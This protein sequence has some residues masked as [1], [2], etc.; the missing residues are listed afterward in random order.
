MKLVFSPHYRLD[1]GPHV[2]PTVKYER[3]RD[4]I[5]AAGLAAPEDFVEPAP[6]AW[7]DLALVHTSAY[8]ERVRT[9]R[10]SFLEQIRLE[11]PFTPAVVTGFRLMTGGTILAARLALDE[12]VAVHLGGGLHHA[13]ADH[14]EGFCLFNDVA[15]AIRVLQRD[16]LIRRAAV[17]DLDVHQ[18]NG[19]A[20]IFAGDASVFTCSL[21]QQNNYPIEKP[22]SGADIGLRDGASDEEYLAALE[23]VWPRVEAARPDLLCY[24]AGA[25]PFQDDQLGGLALTREGLRRRDRLVLASAVAAQVPVVVLLA[26]GYARRLEDTVAIHVATVEEAVACARTW[27]RADRAHRVTPA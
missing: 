12:G 26:G 20:A 6:A 24:L 13:F 4:A 22:P 11:I 15:V 9:G 17:V 18:G 16:G 25:D 8:L 19:T 27:R 14:G 7:T 3:V 5:L 10:F 23:G 2:W 21:H 1:L